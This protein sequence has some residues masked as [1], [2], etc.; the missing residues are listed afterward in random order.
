VLVIAMTTIGCGSRDK[1]SWA[2]RGVEKTAPKPVPAAPTVAPA[3]TP[4]SSSSVVAV[5]EPKREARAA[6]VE[7]RLGV[8]RL[9]VATG[10][11]DREPVGEATTFSAESAAKIYAFVEVTNQDR[12]ASQVVV[13]F[14]PETG[15]PIGHVKLEVG[16]APRWRTWATTRALKPGKWQAVVRDGKGKVLATS[17]FV[18][19]REQPTAVQPAS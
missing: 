19:E 4:A 6:D 12:I 10:V 3:P 9:V 16:A 8:K 14:E 7:A 1:A 15:S 17:E 5:N 18:V 2:E 11:K 13:T